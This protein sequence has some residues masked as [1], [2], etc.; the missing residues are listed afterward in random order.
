M[1]KKFEFYKIENWNFSKLD[2]D[3]YCPGIYMLIF[4]NGMRYLGK[5][6]HINE[7][8]RQH[9][10]AFSFA[11]DWHSI[12]RSTFT[13]LKLVRPEPKLPDPTYKYN[14][15]GLIRDYQ[16]AHYPEWKRLTKKRRDIIYKEY[17]VPLYREYL[18]SVKIHDREEK[19]YWED[20]YNMSCDF[21]NNV[22][23]CIWKVPEEDIT[24][25]ENLCLNQIAIEEKKFR[26]YNKIYPK[27]MGGDK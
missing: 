9:F 26:Y 21:F 3:Y 16:N 27:N 1:N 23:L 25:A 18:E 4:P 14:M 17:I 2:K 8:I 12:A 5:S 11:S 6:I 19:K 7:R 13:K 24:E 10:K 15:P 20:Y 22:Q